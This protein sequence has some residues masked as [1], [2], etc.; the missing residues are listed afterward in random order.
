MNCS[1]AGKLLS[2]NN[3][4]E[5]KNSG[6]SSICCSAMNDWIW[7]MRAAII[8]PNAVSVTA[9]SSSSPKTVR[10]NVSE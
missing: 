6:M 5:R 8:T 7:L 4:P 10:N 9:S 2:G 1:Q 3:A